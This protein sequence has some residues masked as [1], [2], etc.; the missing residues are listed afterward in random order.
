MGKLVNS[1]AGIVAVVFVVIIVGSIVFVIVINLL[2]TD[3]SK[4][5]ETDKINTVKRALPESCDGVLST[6][7]Y[8]YPTADECATLL[9]LDLY[10][11]CYND[12]TLS[13]SGRE[14]CLDN[15]DRLLDENCR[16]LEK[17]LGI[18]YEVCVMDTL[19]RTYQETGGS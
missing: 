2:Y 13:E 18:K 12:T 5:E 10:A 1:F 7:S 11:P 14:A 16:T 15:L 8:L 19:K 17:S 6:E 4:A 9:Y 3:G